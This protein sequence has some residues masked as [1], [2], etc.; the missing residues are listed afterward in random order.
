MDLCNFTSVP[1][2]HAEAR[3]QTFLAEANR[4]G[5]L[6]LV[7]RERTA[8]AGVRRQLGAGLIRAGELLR[9]PVAP[10]ANPA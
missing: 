8:S 10:V 5:L 2:L 9:G 7:A 1:H 6:R 4:D 3:R